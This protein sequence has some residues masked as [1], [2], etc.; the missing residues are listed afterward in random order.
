[1]R[2]TRYSNHAQVDVTYR[3]IDYILDVDILAIGNTGIGPYDIGEEHPLDRGRD[4]V[5]DWTISKIRY[6]DTEQL[7][8][9]EADEIGLE[10]AEDDALMEYIQNDLDERLGDMIDDSEYDKGDEA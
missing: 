4:Y 5:E 3:G 9:A 7:S 6:A 10:M 8:K 1:M 2:K